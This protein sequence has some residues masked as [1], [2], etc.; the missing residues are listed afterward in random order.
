M[1]ND[2][3]DKPDDENG[4]LHRPKGFDFSKLEVEMSEEERAAADERLREQFKDLSEGSANI[5]DALRGIGGIS[6]LHDAMAHVNNFQDALKAVG[7]DS[8]R[9]ADIFRDHMSGL[10]GAGV[11]RFMAEQAAME[12]ARKTALGVL[13]AGYMD[14]LTGSAAMEK[15]QIAALG[16]FPEGYMDHLLGAQ[17]AASRLMEEMRENH[18]FMF[19]HVDMFADTRRSIEAATSFDLN[20]VLI[21]RMNFFNEALSINRIGSALAAADAASV[22]GLHPDFNNEILTATSLIS[23]QVSAFN[24]AREAA[25]AALRLGLPERLEEMLARSIA[26]QEALVDEYREAAK[27][28][29]VE[30]VFHRRNATISMIINILMLLLAL[31]L[32]IEERLTDPDEAVRANTEAVRELQQSFDDMAAQMQRMNDLQVSASAEEQAADGAIADLLREIADSLAGQDPE[33]AE[34]G[35]GSQRSG[36]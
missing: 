31:T 2:P 13:P 14:I 22:L 17:T 30:A 20:S 28:A 35:S 19:Q 8:L 32:Q 7:L 26:A 27:D 16:V 10:T 33:E 15:A 24:F 25:S 6:A 1:S 11:D 3:D 4:G 34:L 5:R 36:L 21:P 29:K 12:E 9:G 18:R 23:E